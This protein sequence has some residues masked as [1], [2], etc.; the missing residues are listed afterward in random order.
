MVNETSEDGSQRSYDSKISVEGDPEKGYNLYFEGFDSA[1]EVLKAYK[2]MGGDYGKDTGIYG[3]TEAAIESLKQ[4]DT[5]AIFRRLDSPIQEG[6]EW[7]INISKL[8]QKVAE[9]DSKMAYEDAIKGVSASTMYAI[10]RAETNRNLSDSFGLYLDLVGEVGYSKKERLKSQLEETRTEIE[11]YNRVLDT[12]ERENVEIR[13]EVGDVSGTI[14]ELE[15]YL[16]QNLEDLKD[17]LQRVEELTDINR[18]VVE[19]LKQES[20]DIEQRMKN[21][22]QQMEQLD[23]EEEDEQSFASKLPKIPSLQ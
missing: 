17:Q 1:E 6:G 21:V 11:E 8:L 2:S 13:D 3:N 23:R 10:S 7:A 22:E 19:N 12:V 18:R 15:G 9:I 5:W 16:E 4:K 14:G 20:E